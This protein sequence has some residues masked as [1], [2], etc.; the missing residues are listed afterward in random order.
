MNA[1]NKK[2]SLNLETLRSLHGGAL[3]HV[4]GGAFAEPYAVGPPPYQGV[5]TVLKESVD[6]CHEPIPVDPGCDFSKGRQ[7]HHGYP[8]GL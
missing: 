1:R 4:V 5:D 6:F 7:G 2:L 3:K 8:G